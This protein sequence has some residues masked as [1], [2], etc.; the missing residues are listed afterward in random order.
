MKFLAEVLSSKEFYVFQTLQKLK[1]LSLTSF[2]FSHDMMQLLYS[3][4]IFLIYLMVSICLNEKSPCNYLQLVFANCLK[5][6]SQYAKSVHNVTNFLKKY[7]YSHISTPYT[8]SN[9][10]DTAKTNKVLPYK[11]LS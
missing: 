5:I 6:I 4:I 1:A 3:Y 8:T 10:V 11:F 7:C 9:G 2:L